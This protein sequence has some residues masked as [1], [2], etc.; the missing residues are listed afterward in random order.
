MYALVE[1]G[2]IKKY[3]YTLAQLRA[4]NPN[5]S[6]PPSPGPATLAGFNMLVVFNSVPPDYD[7]ETQVIEESLPVFDN[8]S[9]RWTQAWQIRD[10]SSEESQQRYDAQANAIR[11]D[12]NA[13]LAACDWTQLPDAP[14][15]ST[16]WAAYR[17]A[18]RDVTSQA[19]FPWNVV[20]PEPPA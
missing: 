16:S 17:Q 13:R 2:V 8:D 9:K 20:W 3:P 19:G 14:V 1:N 12:R 5:T 6:F 10:L 4:D 7:P 18:L 15:D 11:A